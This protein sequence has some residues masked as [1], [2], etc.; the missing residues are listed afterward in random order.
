M[1]CDSYS[2]KGHEMDR[3]EKRWTDG[4]RH[5]RNFADKQSLKD[6]VPTVAQCLQYSITILCYISAVYLLSCMWDTHVMYDKNDLKFGWY[7]KYIPSVGTYVPRMVYAGALF[8]SR[9]KSLP[10]ALFCQWYTVLSILT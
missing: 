4:G 5:C 8:P 3:Q 10:K 7:E 2:E 9:Q 1:E 6:T